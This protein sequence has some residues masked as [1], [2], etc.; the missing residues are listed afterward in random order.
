MIAGLLGTIHRVE[1]DAV[2]VNVG[3][4][5]YRVL[6]T[7]RVVSS[8]ASMSGEQ[9]FI[10]HMVVREDAQLLY[11]FLT[12]AD[13]QW[14]QTLIGVNGIGPRM[15]LAILTRFSAD[16]L[17]AVIA[18]EQVD[19]LTTVSGIGKRTAQRIIL[20]LRGKLPENLD[21]PLANVSATNN[22]TLEALMALGYTAGEAK[23]AISRL[24]L[25]ETAT[26]EDQIVAAL[27]EMATA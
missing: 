14:F 13:V 2:I 15:A 11:G 6:T 3:G 20:D 5:L 8:A 22:D 7:G 18:D 9:E 24:D 19:M 17:F 27:R 10:T 1:P 21:A 23:T 16:E 26:V 4:V 25:P 12:P